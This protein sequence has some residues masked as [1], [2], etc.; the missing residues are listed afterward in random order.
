M[1]TLLRLGAQLLAVVAIWYATLWLV[2]QLAVLV[3]TVTS[4]VW[5]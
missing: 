2:W 1:K 5:R 4:Q 3:N